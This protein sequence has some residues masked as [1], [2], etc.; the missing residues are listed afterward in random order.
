MGEFSQVFSQIALKC[1]YVARIGSQDTLWS[2]S[3]FAR[4]VTKWT[5]ACD[6]R[7]VRLIPYIH[8]T[9]EFRHHCHVGNTAQHCRLGIF[10]D[11]DFAGDLEDSKSTSEEVLRVFGSRTRV[12]ISWMLLALDLWEIVIEVLRSTNNT[13]RHGK[14]AQR[15]LCETGEHS[16]KENKTR[17][18]TETRKR[19]IEQLSNVDCVPSNTHSS[20]GES[21]LYIFCRQRSCLQDD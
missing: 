14:L 16:T 17:T 6:R 15:D 3:K 8:Y 20:Q 4:A 18:S 13:A 19:K 7:L 11:S 2:V 9:N 12:P 1:F 5:Q 10:Q 21:Q